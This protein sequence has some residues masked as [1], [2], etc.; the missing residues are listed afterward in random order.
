MKTLAILANPRKRR[1]I[2]VLRRIME[3]AEGLGL[4]VV[5]DEATAHILPDLRGMPVPEV[6]EGADMVMALGGDGTMLRVVREL[7]GRDIPVIG[8]NVGS[9]GFLTSV[10]EDNLERALLCISKGEFEVEESTVL[11]AGILR[12]GSCV[13]SYH[14]INDI[15]VA[16]G[17]SSRVIAVDLSIDGDEVTT[18]VC[19]GLIVSTPAGSTGYCLSAGGPILVPSAQAFVISLICP[20]TLSSRPLVVCDTCTIKIVVRDPGEDVLVSADGQVGMSLR[21]ADEVSITRS[22]RKARF[23]HLPEH[24]Y[25]SV[26]RQ[27]LNWRGSSM[28]QGPR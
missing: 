17:A 3:R 26:L 23:V 21:E 16:R 15:V 28:K 12:S 4:S 1:A 10:S 18:Y 14:G 6:F 24:S 5:A 25:F 11:E 27:K 2:D 9:L 8:V 20:H 22:S 19:D 7:A 13:G